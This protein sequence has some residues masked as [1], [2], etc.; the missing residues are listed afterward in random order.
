MFGFGLFPHYKKDIQVLERVQRKAHIHVKRIRKQK[1][2]EAKE[3]GLFLNKKGLNQIFTHSVSITDTRL[4]IELR[5][6]IIL[7]AAKK[8]FFSKYASF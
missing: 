1:N 2:T 6:F 5:F 3:Y 8:Y 4:S 7:Y